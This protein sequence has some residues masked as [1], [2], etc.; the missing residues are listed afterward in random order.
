MGN[1]EQQENWN[2][3]GGQSWVH[4]Q[5]RIDRAVQAFSAES[6]R[7]LGAAPGESIIDVGCGAGT[8]TLALA[9]AVGENGKVLGLDFSEP[10]LDLARKRCASLPQVSLQHGDAGQPRPENE[11]DALFSRFGVMFFDQ[12]SVAFSNLRRSLRKNGRMTFMCWQNRD[13]NPW[14]MEPMAAMLPFLSE[15][16]PPPTPHA[17]GAFGLADKDYT[18]GVLSEAGFKDIEI[19]PITMDMVLGTEGV[20]SA[21]DF[22]MKL[23][24]AAHLAKDLPPSTVEKIEAAFT[25]LFEQHESQGQVTLPGS[26]WI[27]TGRA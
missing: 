15:T 27:V 20:P 1:L 4:Y 12:P 23:G 21:V 9:E 11:F 5:E 25:D 8:T 16:P 18:R 3:P 2:G 7:C 17:P 22:N 13:N 14:V 26:A 10:L 24:P 19:D 6:L